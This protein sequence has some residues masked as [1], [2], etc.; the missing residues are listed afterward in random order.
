MFQV[1]EGKLPADSLVGY[2]PFSPM[3]VIRK[4]YSI[5]EFKF[6]LLFCSFVE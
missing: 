1:A 5:D 4:I 6:I 3:K 2:L